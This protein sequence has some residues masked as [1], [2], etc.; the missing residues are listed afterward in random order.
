MTDPFATLV[1]AAQSAAQA[2]ADLQQTTDTLTARITQLEAQLAALQPKTLWGSSVWPYGG[3]SFASALTRV[4]AQL[5]PQVIRFYSTSGPSWPTSTGDA[6][7][8]L[9][10]KIAPAQVLD[11]SH[12]AQLTSFFARTPRPTFWSYWHEPEND[13]LNTADYRAAWARIAGLAKASGKP[14]TAT[15]ILMDWSL[16]PKSGRTWTDYY[17]GPDVIDVLGWD[18]Y[19]WG[20]KSTPDAV[21]GPVIAASKAAGKPWAVAETGVPSVQVSDPAQRQQMLTATARYLASADPAP[22]F[23]TYF[24]S[25]PGAPKI[26]YGWNVSHDPAASAAWVAGQQP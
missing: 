18:A 23:V 2:G 15:L 12:D 9:S 4:Q 13:G 11:G 20:P 16:N 14:L 10:F 19:L 21:F 26:R 24:D 5:K 1:S 3:E 17:P 22:V 7:L 6:P 8:V 25:D